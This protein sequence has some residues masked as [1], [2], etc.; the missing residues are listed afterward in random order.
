MTQLLRSKPFLGLLLLAILNLLLISVQ[1]RNEHGRLLLRSWGLLLFTPVA[2]VSSLAATGFSNSL[3]FLK[4]QQELREENQLLV[5]ENA[6]LQT[7]LQQL[8]QMQLLRERSEALKRLEL[9]YSF[10]TVIAE[11]IWKSFPVHS[12]SLVIGLGE[13]AGIRRDAAVLTQDGLVGR[14]YTTTL[15]SAEVQLISDPS[16]AAGALIGDSRLQGIVQGEGE[17][18]LSLNYI[19]SGETVGVGEIVYTSGMDRVYPKG[20]PI[21]RILT[22]ERRGV[23]QEIRVEPF[24]DF[25]RIEEVSVVVNL[26]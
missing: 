23:Y 16:A 21:G 11:I 14:V 5:S 4:S 3:S 12:Q 25:Q 22:V 8:R 19:P 7:Q 26:N 6:R 18:L 15:S 13:Y 17:E 24:V 10:D 2:F 20:I 1:V 9:L